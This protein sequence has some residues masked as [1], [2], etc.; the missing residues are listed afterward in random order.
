MISKWKFIKDI[1][2]WNVGRI[3]FFQNEKIM[4]KSFKKKNSWVEILI[5]RDNDLQMVNKIG[6]K[7][8]FEII[9]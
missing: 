4:G 3:F 6:N 5:K 8:R 2:N 7:I 1:K 9:R